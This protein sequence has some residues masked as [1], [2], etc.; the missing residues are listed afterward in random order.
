MT[1]ADLIDKINQ[2]DWEFSNCDTQI[3]STNRGNSY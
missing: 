1:E 2:I 3:Y